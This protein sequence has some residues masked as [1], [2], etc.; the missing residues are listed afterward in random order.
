MNK[1]DPNQLADDY[2]PFILIIICLLVVIV[3][4]L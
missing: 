3:S 2:G 4:L 1:W